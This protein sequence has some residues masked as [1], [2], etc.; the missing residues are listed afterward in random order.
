MRRLLRLLPLP[1]THAR[2][3]RA[4]LALLT[5]AVTT[6]ALA[7]VATD[8]PPSTPTPANARSSPVSAATSPIGAADAPQEATATGSGTP[9]SP[10][11]VL[12]QRVV[13][14]DRSDQHSG[15]PEVM[16]DT[17]ILVDI[18]RRS[19]LWE[20]SPHLA[21]PPASTAKL[22][23]ALVTLEN[24]D[25][26]REVTITP[27]ALGQAKDETV[28]G[29]AAGQSYTVGELLDGML[30]PSG[31]DAATALAADTVGLEQFVAAENLQLG[32]LGLHDSHV[33]TPVGLDDPAQ[34]IS[35]YDLAAVAVADLE[36]FPL[37]SQI[38][39]QTDVQLAATPGHP[40]FH[41]ANLNR[42]LRLY[43]G[44]RG[45]KPGYTGDA[46]PCLVGLAERDGHR[47]IAV[48][49][50]APRLYTDDRALL[51]WGFAQE[52]LAPL[53]SP[54]PSPKPTPHS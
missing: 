14:I 54:T 3:L 30:L 36:H 28:M 52:G 20:R 45:I 34:Q 2:G 19:I 38:V 29:I 27:D 31:N 26:E 1:R 44:V 17:G 11:R 8:R 53:L 6:A 18:D 39:A 50:G 41:L 16:A 13:F 33:V 42:L 43:P 9:A 7:L 35:A 22:L 37:F 5:A 15:A 24:F 46:G 25:P 47:L 10:M 51:D 23:T 21:H 32:A 48:L 4:R 49:M 12:R 40:A